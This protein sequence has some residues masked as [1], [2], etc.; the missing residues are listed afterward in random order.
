MFILSFGVS[1]V[2]ILVVFII[3]VLAKPTLMSAKRLQIGIIPGL[4]V[5]FFTACF[6]FVAE[7]MDAVDRGE[8]GISAEDIPR[9]LCCLNHTESYLCKQGFYQVFC[10]ASLFAAPHQIDHL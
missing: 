7:G 3:V 9:G 1:F 5:T 2:D 10:S 8:M 6:T 4:T